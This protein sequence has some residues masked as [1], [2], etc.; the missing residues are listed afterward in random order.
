MDTAATWTDLKEAVPD[1]ARLSPT[2][3]GELR[4]LSEA[5]IC[6][7]Q[8]FRPEHAGSRDIGLGGW[9]TT[10]DRVVMLP[11][12]AGGTTWTSGVNFPMTDSVPSPNT[13]DRGAGD[14]GLVGGT[15]S[16]QIVQ[17]ALVSEPVM[18]VI[19]SRIPVG[20]RAEAGAGTWKISEV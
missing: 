16:G 3:L 9:E 17:G 13:R 10:E 12:T 20:D 6:T 1:S 7:G 4:P 15:T 18:E 11:V 8:S 19:M 14:T 2:Q 5:M